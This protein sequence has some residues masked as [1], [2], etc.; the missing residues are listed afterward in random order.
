[1]EQDSKR[2]GGPGGITPWRDL[3]ASILNRAM[4][5]VA[6]DINSNEAYMAK[7]L[8]V[9][10]EEWLRT[11]MWAGILLDGLDINVNGDFLANQALARRSDGQTTA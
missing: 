2:R 7:K 4:D 3:A 8:A 9:S 5:D 1:M 6:G 10:A 11:D